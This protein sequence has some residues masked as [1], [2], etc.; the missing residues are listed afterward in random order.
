M[1]KFAN[2]K[3]TLKTKTL[4]TDAAS[5]KRT[6]RSPNDAGAKP[7]KAYSMLS[8]SVG[9]SLFQRVSKESPPRAFSL[10]YGKAK[11]NKRVL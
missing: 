9:V 10:A 3:S 5:E 7:V 4:F 6:H 11:K 1:I 2:K 8:C